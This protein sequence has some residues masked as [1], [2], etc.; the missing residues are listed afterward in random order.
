MREIQKVVVKKDDKYL[1]LLRSKD[2][3]FFPECWDFPGGK[4]EENEEPYDGIEREVKEETNLDVRA[5][6]VLGVYE[7]FLEEKKEELIFTV[8]SIEIISGE[9][10]LSSEHS[11]L[12]SG[13]LV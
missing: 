3:E 13:I 10:K 7:Y 6:G 8:Y 4:L 5:T 9:V 2:A 1:I 11:S 12:S